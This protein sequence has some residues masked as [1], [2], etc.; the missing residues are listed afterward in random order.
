M[1]SCGNPN[2]GQIQAFFLGVQNARS[3]NVCTEVWFDELRLSQINDQGGYAAMGRV[4]IKLADLGTMY[5]AGSIRSVG[6]GSIDQSINQRSLDDRTQLDAAANLEL[7]KLLP[8]K[9]GISIP[10]YGSISKSVSLPEYDPFDL[11]IKL[12]DKINAAPASK[13]DSIR[14]Q[15]VDA[16]T[17][18]SFNFTNVRRNNVTG[19][20]LK[21]WSIENFDVSYSY[22]S[23]EHHNPV[24]E[25]DEL[26]NV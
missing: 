25:E 6:F 15:A 5:L 12:K 2:I 20:K 8:K 21:L 4:D 13:K 3:T 9:A 10:F 19:K 18:K 1:R 24:A 26:I 7:G 22:T 16:T 11:D 23:S 14:E 17:I